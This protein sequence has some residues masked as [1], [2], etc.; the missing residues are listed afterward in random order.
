M[1]A[2]L[3]ARPRVID[4]LLR[5]GADFKYRDPNGLTALVLA[6]HSYESAKI[7]I[8]AGADVNTKSKIGLT[9]FM[10]AA[11]YPGNTALLTLMLKKGA[12]AKVSALGATCAHPGCPYGGCRQHRIVASRAAPTQM[13]LVRPAFPL[14][15]L[16]SCAQTVI[17]SSCF[18]MPAPTLRCGQQAA[19]MCLNAMGSGTIRLWSGCCWNEG[20]IQQQKT[21]AA[22]TPSSSRRPQIRSRRRFSPCC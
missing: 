4:M 15:T 1:Y 11:A 16:P 17:W 22:T 6:A 13:R 7:L 14:F 5:A 12:D 8:D 21:P 9:P 20:S 2:A 19:R 10:T 3:Y 18:S